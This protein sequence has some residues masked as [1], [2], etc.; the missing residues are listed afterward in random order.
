MTSLDPA[1]GLLTLINTFEVEPA[2]ADELM[3]VLS[4]A[5]EERMRLMTGFVSANLHL[6]RD[7]RHVANYAQWRSQ[8]DMDAMLANPEAQVH[9]REAAAI[10]TSFNPIVYDLR[11]V[12]EA[13]EAA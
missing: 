6:S 3:A 7:K 4:K 1:A 2:R 5:T 11:E 8:A 12:H 10:A 9:M 13:A